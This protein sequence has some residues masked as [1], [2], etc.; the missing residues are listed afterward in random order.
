[1]EKLSFLKQY[2]KEVKLVSLDKIES[3]GE[4]IIPSQWLEIV[5]EKDKSIRLKNTRTMEKFI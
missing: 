3:I 5:I 1:M 4:D 2:R